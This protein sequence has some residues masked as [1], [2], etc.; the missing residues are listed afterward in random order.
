M[1]DEK[2]KTKMFLDGVWQ[3]TRKHPHRGYFL[4]SF[5]SPNGWLSWNDIVDEYLVAKKYIERGDDRKMQVVWNT[6]FA[7]PWKKVI[8]EI[9]ITTNDRLEDYG[10]EVPNGVFVLTAGVDIQDDRVEIGVIGHGKLG[11]LYYIDYKVIYDDIINETTKEALDDYLIYKE[12]YREDGRAMK[13]QGTAI[14]TGGHRTKQV[15]EYVDDRIKYNIFGVKGSSTKNAP[16]IN[17]RAFDLT[18]KNLIILGTNSLKDDFFARLGVTER[19]ENYVHFPNRQ[20]F[21][22]RFFKMLTAEVRNPDGSYK[23]IRKRNEAIDLSVYALSVINILSIDVDLM[24]SPKIF[25]E[26]RPIVNTVNDND[27]QLSDYLD[28]Y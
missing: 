26:D 20:A 11:E 4:P 24:K 9:E 12:F 25:Y 2:H 23:K 7:L 16:P 28:E 27:N 15:Y 6:H 21:N 1:I 17:K 14:D 10:C 18:D 13:I 19:G 3:P 22:E 8:K 5:Y